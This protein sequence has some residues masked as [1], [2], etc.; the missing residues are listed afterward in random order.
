MTTHSFSFLR[1]GMLLLGMAFVST[2]ALAQL[3]IEITT[4]GGKQIPV[5]I[6]PFVS[7]PSLGQP[8]TQ[9]IAQDLVR[10]G[11]F[12]MV[13]TAGAQTASP[14]QANYAEWQGKGAE[15][16]VTGLVS[17][18]PDGRFDVKFFLFD[19][20]K[21]A[22]IAGFEFS[23]APAQVR[24]TAHKIADIIYE[25]MTGDKGVFSTR[26]AYVV[27]R[28]A[29]RYEL[30]VSDYDGFGAQTVLSSDEPIMSPAWSPD[31]SKLAYVS[32][33]GRRPRVYVQDLVTRDRRAVAAFRGTN[34]APTWAPDGRSLLVAL[35]RDSNTQIFRV[36]ATGGDPTRLT[37][38]G[39]IDT[40]PVFSPDGGTIFFTSD[41]GGAPQ[42][43]KMSAGGG[44]A[45]RVTFEGGYNTSP[46]LSPDGKLLTYVN[47]E[48]GRFRVALL[49]LDNGQV[50][51]LSDGP[52]DDRPTFARNG[53]VILYETK[54]GGR[55]TLATVSVDGKVKQRLSSANGDVRT[56]V[57]GR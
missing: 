49:E 16:L 41:R 12:K 33:E 42:I 56:P 34:S 51:Y 35:T 5:A 53:K 54:Q 3:T 22:N 11:Q 21:Q 17:P 8:L 45:Q 50:S 38:S 47:R 48:S 27:K 13:P 57:W 26:I 29:N 40:E 7:E 39:S 23:I 55:G 24:A 28:S 10:T 6:M 18:R 14:E 9:V 20:V 46:S 30:Q 1:R 44:N 19:V 32:F 43:Y 37:S 4:Q 36:G 25:K 31:S 52:I 15:G 2:A